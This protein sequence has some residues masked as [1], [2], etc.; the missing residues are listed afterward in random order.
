MKSTASWLQNLKVRASW[1]MLGNQSA[2]DD[3]YFPYLPTLYIGKNF[4]FDGKVA[5][6]ITVVN[7]KVNSITWEKSRTW[8]FGFD[9]TL[10]KDLTLSA[11]YYNRLTTDIIMDIS[12]PWTFGISG[13]FQDNRGKML[14]QGIE[15][16]AAWRH[17]FSGDW[18]LGVVA[19]YAFNHNEILDL[20]EVDEMIS[21]YS[22]NR[23]GEAYGS[24][25]VYRTNGVFSSDEEAAEYEKM[26][27]NPF[28]VAYKGGDLIIVDTNRDGKITTDD[29]EVIGSK[30]PVHTY[31]LT[32][33]GGWKGINLSVFLQGAAD[34]YRYFGTDVVGYFGGDTTHPSTN[35]LD[36]WTPENPNA[37]W[38]RT[39]KN[40]NSVS[41][42]GKVY[43]DFWCR[44]TSYLRIKTVNLSYTL[45][46]NIA[47][48]LHTSSIKVYY[49]A[50][51][52]HT[53]DALPF[54]VDPEVASGNIEY[55]PS[56]SSHSFGVNIT[57]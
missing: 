15:L 28:K 25:Y 43:S 40:E 19:N 24:F 26:F 22:I 56:S 2:L 12:V 44:N 18:R 50:E 39:F 33:E 45:P 31:G 1:G 23:V 10:F 21:G 34:V 8:G 14:N 4:P 57:F 35:W 9:A 36:A 38:P 53:F 13:T 55:Y 11:D 49:A 7:H 52:L 16:Q 17:N 41:A 48:R 32:L 20:A 42:P 29:R 30:Y 47:K 27:G 6:G 5:T 54:N 3:D 51:N 37:T 46:K